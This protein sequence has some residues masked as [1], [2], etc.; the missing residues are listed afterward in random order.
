MSIPLFAIVAVVLLFL[1][2]ALFQSTRRKANL[3]AGELVQ[4]FANQV[5]QGMVFSAIFRMIPF[6]LLIC[7]IVFFAGIGFDPYS[8]RISMSRISDAAVAYFESATDKKSAPGGTRD[9]VVETPKPKTEEQTDPQHY[10]HVVGPEPKTVTKPVAAPA[11]GRAYRLIAHADSYAQAL[12]HKTEYKNYLPE[13]EM[14]LVQYTVPSSN[15]RRHGLQLGEDKLTFE[16]A[17][18]LFN[19]LDAKWSQ[20]SG[21][22]LNPARFTILSF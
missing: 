20:R 7:V 6:F 22:H 2:W 1:V 15:E 12:N 10:S 8:G 17:Q 16:E 21:K 3:N 14:N 13:I 9:G 18:A 11:K 4:D 5:V 19:A